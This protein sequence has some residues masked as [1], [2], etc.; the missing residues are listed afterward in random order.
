MIPIRPDTHSTTLTR[1]VVPQ[2]GGIICRDFFNVF[3]EKDFFFSIW[4][5]SGKTFGFVPRGGRGGGGF[6]A[7]SSQ[8][9]GSVRSCI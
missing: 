2:L 4:F 6:K 8:Y 3:Q 1:M 7:D 5:R 9:V